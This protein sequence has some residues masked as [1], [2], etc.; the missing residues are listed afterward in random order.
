MLVKN[1][2]INLVHEVFGKF[3][4]NGRDE[5]INAGYTQVKAIKTCDALHIIGKHPDPNENGEMIIPMS[6]ISM[7]RVDWMPGSRDPTKA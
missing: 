5:W 2:R 7:L 6:N 4:V 1:I 3:S